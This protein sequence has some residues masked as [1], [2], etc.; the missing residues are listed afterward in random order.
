[1]NFHLISKGHGQERTK[2]GQSA[3]SLGNSHPSVG[4]DH[5][6]YHHLLGQEC[7]GHH[8]HILPDFINQRTRVDTGETK[9]GGPALSHTTFPCGKVVH[10][11]IVL[12]ADIKVN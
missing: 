9:D 12:T 4:V 3:T 10:F 1:M 11:E 8:P 7:H 2:G 5:I 6:S